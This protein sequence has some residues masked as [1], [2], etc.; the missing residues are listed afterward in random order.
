MTST[1][2]GEVPEPLRSALL[3]YLWSGLDTGA[4]L[5]AE[6][7]AGAGDTRHWTALLG[8]Q[9]TSA[10]SGAAPEVVAAVAA[11]AQDRLPLEG[12]DREPVPIA[13]ADITTRVGVDLT[14]LL[15]KFPVNHHLRK[16]LPHDGYS[17]VTS[18]GVAAVTEPWPAP[19]GA[20]VPSA[21][22]L[23]PARL[24]VCELDAI[25]AVWPLAQD[26]PAA[27][28]ERFPRHDSTRLIALA[29]DAVA[30][31]HLASIVSSA[32]LIKNLGHRA[33]ANH[34]CGVDLPYQGLTGDLDLHRAWH[35]LPA[36]DND[37]YAVEWARH[38]HWHLLSQDEDLV[39]LSELGCDNVRAA[40]DDPGCVK[41][42]YIEELL[43]HVDASCGSPGCLSHPPL[44]D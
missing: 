33:D 24:Y 7:A 37:A 22:D 27:I 21:E 6:I 2:T 34:P 44:T 30:T 13:P 3:C 43:D 36:G 10:L 8:H 4:D 12:W 26:G 9:I 28:T 5:T 38:R 17:L 1:N 18:R 39:V 19:K 32:D 23:L 14:R 35:Q 16:T 29:R 25:A 41:S 20:R 11:L 42:D 15:S 31:A 40:L